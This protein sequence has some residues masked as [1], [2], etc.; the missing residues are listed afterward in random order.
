VI[1]EFRRAHPAKEVRSL[2]AFDHK[3]F[4]RSDWFSTAQWR[5]YESYWMLVDGRKAG[6]CAFERHADF[7]DDLREDGVD[8]HLRGCLHI[9]SSGIL[10]RDRG[11]GLGTL[12]KAWQVSFA[13]HHRFVRMVT[14]SRRSNRAMIELNKNFGFRTV[15]TTRGYYS[16]PLESAVV[17]ER[18]L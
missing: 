4:P 7:Q 16:S 10:P 8:P 5:A 11:K 1:V 18:L 2:V 6:C 13:R 14:C 17:M 15:R 12:M 3:V 9:V